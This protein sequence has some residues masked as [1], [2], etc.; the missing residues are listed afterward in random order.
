MASETLPPTEQ[1]TIT[2]LLRR[3][4]NGIQGIIDR[5]IELARQEIKEN[6][7]QV[8]KASGLL[9]AGLAVLLVAIIF[10]FVSLIFAIDTLFPGYGW[11]AGLVLTA[12]LAI[13]GAILTLI[14]KERIKVSPIARTRETLME[15]I[16]WVRH[17]LTP[18][19]K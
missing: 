1:Q 15:D 4:I 14:G 8:A 18:N 7:A 2:D 12:I 17:P 9:A 11:V 5:Q 3:V 19:G 13:V 16:E 10:L 6:I